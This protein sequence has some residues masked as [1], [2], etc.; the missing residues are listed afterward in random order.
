[1]E[2]VRDQIAYAPQRAFLFSISIRE[3]IALGLAPGVDPGSEEAAAQIRRAVEAAGLEVDLDG[4]TDGLDTVV[5]ERGL[6]L[7]GGQRQRVALA[8]A[9]VS[10]R[11]VLVLDDS[12]SSVDSSTE[13][14]ILAQL[15]AVLEGRTAILISHRLSALQHAQQVV[16]LDEGRVTER[17]THE[18]LLEAGGVYAELY[19]K[20]VLEE[21]E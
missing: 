10:D 13:K 18:E 1:M 2:Q 7:S 17:G 14:R 3:N 4:F 9:L 8:R 15:Q 16:V 19:R 6:S 20:Q 21:L 11:R 12:L 5:G